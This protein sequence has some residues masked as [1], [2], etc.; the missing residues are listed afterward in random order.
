MLP[1]TM[2]TI[3]AAGGGLDIDC[4]KRVLLPDYMEKIAAAAAASGKH[5]QIIFRNVDLLLPNTAEKIAKAGQGCVV[6]VV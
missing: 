3:A 2:L 4:S 1:T 5:P 6:F